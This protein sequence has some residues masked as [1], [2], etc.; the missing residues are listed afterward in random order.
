MFDIS[1]RSF[2]RADETE[3]EAQMSAQLPTTGKR[4]REEFAVSVIELGTRMI[5]RD[6]QRTT[7]VWKLSHASDIVHFNLLNKEA[8]RRAWANN[9]GGRSSK[10]FTGRHHASDRP[11]NA[12]V[13]SPDF[14]SYELARQYHDLTPSLLLSVGEAAQDVLPLAGD[15]SP[16]RKLVAFWVKGV[17]SHR[18]SQISRAP[19][20]HVQI[21]AS[22]QAEF[23][24][25]LSAS[26]ATI[27]QQRR[28]ARAREAAITV[29]GRFVTAI[30]DQLCETL[31]IVQDEARDFLE[32]LREELV[33]SLLSG[34]E[35]R[36]AWGQIRLNAA[37]DI[38]YQL[39]DAVFV[40]DESFVKS[41]D[42]E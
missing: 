5:S 36:G 11:T 37:R 41:E 7:G 17:L 22:L 12:L 40:T 28:Y 4:D 29:G 6:P 27:G 18:P 31:Q 42:V 9:L 38:E 2:A 35:M 13:L 19:E 24:K 1:D 30:Q 8:I 26:F 39:T 20:E 23:A 21:N 16:S 3:I 15:F 14:L 25:I 33:V 34:A 32:L 10:S